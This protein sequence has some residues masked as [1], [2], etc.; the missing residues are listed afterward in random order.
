MGDGCACG[1]WGEE[2]MVWGLGG[3]CMD[4]VGVRG[5]YAT[6]ACV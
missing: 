3:P 2:S 6:Y 5:V 1:A 4:M